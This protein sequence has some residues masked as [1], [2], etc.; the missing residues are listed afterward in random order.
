MTKESNPWRSRYPLLHQFFRGYLHEDFP[1]EYGSVAGA[2]RQ[3]REDAGAEEFGRF[4]AE[5]NGF[6]DETR[7]VGAGEIDRILS[8][9]LGG[10]WHVASVREIARFT[11]A[12]ER[13]GASRAS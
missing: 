4:A 9:D 10:S 1:E 11:E 12:V 5:W 6:L 7:E 8:V 13:S 3:Y 2:L